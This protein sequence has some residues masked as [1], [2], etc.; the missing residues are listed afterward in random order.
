MTP[1]I[2]SFLGSEVDIWSTLDLQRWSSP[3]ARI[4][5]LGCP[6]TAAV[7]VALRSVAWAKA[8]KRG[9][10]RLRRHTTGTDLW[11]ILTDL[12]M[13]I[14]IILGKNIQW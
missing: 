9:G 11:Y 14:L 13:I 12:F 7:A 5:P 1:Q 2:S 8:K 6:L 3:T 10:L 4:A